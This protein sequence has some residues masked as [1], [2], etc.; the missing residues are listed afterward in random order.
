MKL[1]KNRVDG[2]QALLND[3]LDANTMFSIVVSNQLW[4]IGD[5]FLQDAFAVMMDNRNHIHL[6]QDFEQV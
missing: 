3:I 6:L 4:S 5:K 2:H 1:F